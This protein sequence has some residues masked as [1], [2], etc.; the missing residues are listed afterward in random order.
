[1]D[2]RHGMDNTQWREFLDAAIGLPPGR[3][4]VAAVRR[5]VIRRRVMEAAGVAALV[6]LAVLGVT[7][8]VSVLGAAPAPAP[9]HRPNVPVT[10]YV[11]YLPKGKVTGT[12][13]PI[14]AATNTAGKPVSVACSCTFAITP[15]GKTVYVTTKNA[16]IPVSTATNTPGKP[17]PIGANEAYWI[18]M[19][20][21]GKTAY[22]YG[23]ITG[24][25]V[26]PINLATNT[27]GKPINIGFPGG[28]A[29]TPDGKT[30]YVITGRGVVP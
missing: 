4:T 13:T 17:I 8:A 2:N 29:F 10:V 20:P 19:D 12:I 5:R 11:G 23:V 27:P 26:T 7:A 9:E 15:N 22:A 6:V 25:P 16:I 14:S 3:L 28:F 18:V 30:V 1:M 24:A 21:N